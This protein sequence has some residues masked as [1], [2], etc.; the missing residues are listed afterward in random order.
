[1]TPASFRIFGV[2]ARRQQRQADYDEADAHDGLME[3]LYPR[4]HHQTHKVAINSLRCLRANYGIGIY[5]YAT[6]IPFPHLAMIGAINSYGEFFNHDRTNVV[7]YD[8]RLAFMGYED[9]QKYCKAPHIP[10]RE[11]IETRASCAGAVQTS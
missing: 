3:R 9:A 1:M 6:K 8:T 7:S 5:F 11:L 10:L 4:C 2:T